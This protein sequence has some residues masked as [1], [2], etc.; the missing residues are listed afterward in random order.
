[1]SNCWVQKYLILLLLSKIKIESYLWNISMPALYEPF[2][3]GMVKA[4]TSQRAGVS[5]NTQ[6]SSM[7]YLCLLVNVCLINFCIYV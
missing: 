2:I 5:L 1:M 3:Q 7:N 6:D 4:S